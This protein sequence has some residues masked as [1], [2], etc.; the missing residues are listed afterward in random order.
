M[1]AVLAAMDE[2]R[3]TEYDLELILLYVEKAPSQPCSE[4]RCRDLSIAIEA[5]AGAMAVRRDLP[6]NSKLGT[7]L[8]T[9][10]KKIGQVF[11]GT[12]VKALGGFR[13]RLGHRGD[14]DAARTFDLPDVQRMFQAQGWLTTCF[15]R[16]L[17]HELDLQAE[18]PVVDF[19]DLEFSRRLPSTAE[20]AEPGF[21]PER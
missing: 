19:A 14:L 9:L 15:Y 4:M 11:T 16:L 12:E 6:L 1:A 7:T 8:R 10:Q 3:K 21:V 20:F 17:A 2:W 18:V 13:N 5:L